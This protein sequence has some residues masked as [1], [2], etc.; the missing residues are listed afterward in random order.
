MSQ[1]WLRPAIIQSEVMQRCTKVE[2]TNSE[3]RIILYIITVLLSTSISTVLPPGECYCTAVTLS[4]NGVVLPP[5]ERNYKWYARFNATRY[6]LARP[7]L[8]VHFTRECINKLDYG[9][10]PNPDPKRPTTPHG[11][12][13]TKRLYRLATNAI[14]EWDLNGHL[15]TEPEEEPPVPSPPPPPG[16]GA[17]RCSGASCYVWKKF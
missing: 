14:L 15:D 5:S 2:L 4:N 11:V 6:R 3:D 9:F 1:T 17:S 16:R 13:C 10:N 7:I 8:F 12:K